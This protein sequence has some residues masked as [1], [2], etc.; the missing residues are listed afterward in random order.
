MRSMMTNQQSGGLAWT[1]LLTLV[2]HRAQDL[3]VHLIDQQHP[4]SAWLGPTYHCGRAHSHE[5]EITVEEPTCGAC[6][7]SYMTHSQMH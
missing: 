2:F 3:R 1:H 5:D 6:L 7:R 4:H